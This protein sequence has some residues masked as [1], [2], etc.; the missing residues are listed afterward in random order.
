LAGRR[1]GLKFSDFRPQDAED[2]SRIVDDIG[3]V[4]NVVLFIDQLQEAGQAQ[5]LFLEDV[6]HDIRNPIQNLLA[7]V[8]R[9]KLGLVRPDDVQRQM[10][11]VGAQLRRIHQLSQ[12]VWLL[13]Q[14][15]Q[16]KLQLDQAGWVKVHQVIMEAV[17]MVEDVAEDERVAIN[18]APEIEQWRSIKIDQDLFF[19]AMLNLIDNAVKYSYGRTEVRIDGRMKL[20]PRCEISVVNRGVEIKEKYRDKIYKRGF[21]TPEARVHVWQGCGIG[22]CIVKAFADIYGSL[23][24]KC[25]PVTGSSDFVTEFKL[26]V[27]GAIL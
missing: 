22:L 26:I 3:M 5:A 8:D 27:Q 14:V 11:S 20:Y 18:V 15:R 21:R 24:F 9:F 13:E 17:A 12:R 7:K 2:F 25:T 6:A 19:Q 4:M 23:Q 10:T 1:T 16:K